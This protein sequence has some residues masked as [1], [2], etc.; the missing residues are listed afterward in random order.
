MAGLDTSSTSLQA[1]GFVVSDQLKA[2]SP[3]LC[4]VVGLAQLTQAL[5]SKQWV[6]SPVHC[7]HNDLSSNY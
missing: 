2:C 4:A 6:L 3:F 5:L 7:Q 1:E